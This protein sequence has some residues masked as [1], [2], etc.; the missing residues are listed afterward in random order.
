MKT[1]K[2][3]LKKA[4][5]KKDVTIKKILER[6]NVLQNI[7]DA[8][9]ESGLDPQHFYSRLAKE[10]KKLD[11]VYTLV[12]LEPHEQKPVDHNRRYHLVMDIHEI[13]R[14]LNETR[15]ME[16]TCSILGASPLG[17]VGLLNRHGFKIGREYIARDLT[18]EEL[19][20]HV[21]RTEGRRLALL[22]KQKL[23]RALKNKQDV[24]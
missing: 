19:A 21:E 15:N 22:E 17:I 2:K 12:P 9:M 11:R 4:A 10:G 8:C 13:I 20:K 1:Q 16:R 24:L 5:S 18:P 3:P 7:T 14:V 6:M 23:A